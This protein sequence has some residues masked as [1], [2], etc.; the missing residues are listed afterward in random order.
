M[1]QEIISQFDRKIS[2]PLETF[3]QTSTINERDAIPSGIRW[4]GMLV[5]DL[6]TGTTYQ[7]QGGI[8]NSNWEDLAPVLDTVII[9]NL[10]SNQT[11]AALSANQG[12]ILNESKLTS[13]VG[14]TNITIDATDPLNPVINS[15]GGGGASIWGSIT[16]T[17]SNQL[18]LQAA[19]DSKLSN[20]LAG[21]NISIDYGD[22]ANPIISSTAS[23]G[24]PEAPNDG[25]QYGRESLSWT[26]I[27]IPPP[28]GTINGSISNGQ[29]AYGDGTNA[30]QGDNLL[31]Y[32]G[33]SLTSSEQIVN[34]TI[35]WQVSD[36]NNA[37]QRADARS[38]G[39]GAR[40]HWYGTENDAGGNT[41]TGVKWNMYDGNS[42]ATLDWI[43][44]R[45][46]AG[47][48]IKAKGGYVNA[49]R[50]GGS[51]D[52]WIANLGT[53]S[54]SNNFLVGGSTTG[55]LTSMDIYLRIRSIADGGLMYQD[56][57]TSYKVWTAGT[58][59]SG[60]GLD[61]DTVRTYA[62]SASATA[63]NSLA[64]RQSNGDLGFVDGQAQKLLQC[65]L[66]NT[67]ANPLRL[68]GTNTGTSN[69]CYMSIYEGNNATRQGYFGFPSGTSNDMIWYSDMVARS[70]RIRGSDGWLVY[71]SVMSAT[72]F[73]LSSD[74]RKK[75][76]VE[77]FTPH[78]IPWSLYRFDHKDAP[79]DRMLGMIAQE[80]ELTNPEYVNTD[81]EGWKTISYNQ[82]LMAKVAEL[83][84]RIKTL[85]HGRT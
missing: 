14:G 78:H 67:N 65:G 35:R 8:A 17:L 51:G 79:G 80:L 27:S 62:P 37:I 74:I 18:D 57:G 63:A 60:S 3:R 34:G 25:K 56:G 59:G 29:V 47:G 2:F 9:D 83:E 5:Y 61:A 7:L 84:G 58:D 32:D 71:S 66:D 23:G 82:I 26:E 72:D 54:T 48:G 81:A 49:K 75:T 76:R 77:K 73:R 85:E 12:R 43:D 10:T 40:L 15:S 69:I 16:G 21:S 68:Y 41:N 53:S 46:T 13:V 39:F 50:T 36:T 45:M 64:L 55:L 22:P 1:P 52:V 38:D 33:L 70:C 30:I 11:N 44:D 4:E 19:L 24:V 42:Y 6:Q 28:G 20:V 31:T